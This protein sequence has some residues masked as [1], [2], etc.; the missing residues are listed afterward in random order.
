MK[1]E[2]VAHAVCANEWRG[3]ADGLKKEGEAVRVARSV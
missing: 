3:G 2:G 1:T